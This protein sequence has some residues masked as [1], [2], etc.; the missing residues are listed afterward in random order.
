MT[1][2]TAEEYTRITN[3]LKELTERFINGQTSSEERAQILKEAESYPSNLANAVFNV[4]SW[5]YRFELA[6]KSYTVEY[7][8]KFYLEILKSEFEFNLYLG[9]EREENLLRCEVFGNK[10]DAFMKFLKTVDQIK[11]GSYEI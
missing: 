8:A 9:D 4:I 6:G 1:D 11:N 10:Y 3:R 7:K 5:S 2:I